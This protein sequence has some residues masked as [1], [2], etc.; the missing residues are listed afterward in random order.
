LIAGGLANRQS[1][2]SASLGT[3]FKRR[4]SF[5]MPASDP[6][7]CTHSTLKGRDGTCPDCKATLMGRY[8]WP[9]MAATPEKREFSDAEKAAH[10][11][12]QILSAWSSSGVMPQ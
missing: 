6:R 4:R 10:R 12:V 3:S 2:G 7:T 9:F 11:A 8:M 5:I 1:L